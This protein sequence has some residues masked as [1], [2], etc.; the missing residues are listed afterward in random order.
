MQLFSVNENVLTGSQRPSGPAP[1]ASLQ[2]VLEQGGQ[3]AGINR[4]VQLK[5][6]RWSALEE[7]SGEQPRC[8][9]ALLILKHGGVLTHAGRQQV[10]PGALRGAAHS[11]E[12][13]PGCSMRGL[14][15]QENVVSYSLGLGCV[16]GGM[17]LP[18]SL[19]AS[20]PGFV[21]LSALELALAVSAW[22]RCRRR[23]WAT[24][25]ATL[26]TRP[27][28]AAACCACTPPTGTTSKSTPRVSAHTLPAPVSHSCTHVA[29]AGCCS[30]ASICCAACRNGRLRPVL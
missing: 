17:P 27:L 13:R 9:E 30:T 5:P 21:C 26:C 11:H 18:L 14:P 6:L 10:L 1:P 15:E 24:C 20:C 28:R 22:V 2:T 12:P 19:F 29:P 16:L 23:R 25:S 4:K 3:F 8:I 7:G